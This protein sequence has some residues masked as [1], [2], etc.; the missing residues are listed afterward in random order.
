MDNFPEILKILVSIVN[1]VYNSLGPGYNEVVYHRALEVALRLQGINYQS[2]VIVPITY[3][4]YNIGHSRIDLI[5]NDV[6]IELKAL[7]YLNNDPVT[8]IKNYIKQY[9]EVNSI[10]CYG[11]VI[12]FNQKNGNVDKVCIIGENTLTLS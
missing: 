6:I 9:N 7:N 8:Q 1:D 10:I 3:K 4:G 5:V 2:E 11:L 12:N